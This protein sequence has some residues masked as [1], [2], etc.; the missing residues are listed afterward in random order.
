MTERLSGTLWRYGCLIGNLGLEAAEHSEALR[1]RLGQG[2]AHIV[3][4]FAATIAEGQRDGQFRADIPADE[5][6]S[7]LMSAWQGAM[8]WMKVHRSGAAIAT[9]RDVTLPALLLPETEAGC[10]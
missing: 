1:E 9:F 8:L 6:A 2:L 10:K 3:A 4:R 5:L 7:A